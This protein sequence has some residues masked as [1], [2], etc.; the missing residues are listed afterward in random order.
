MKQWPGYMKLET[1]GLKVY[2]SSDDLRVLVGSWLKDAVRKYGIKIIGGEIYSSF[3]S[4]RDPD[5]PSPNKAKAEINPNGSIIIYD[6]KG[7]EGLYLSGLSGQGAVNWYFDGTRYAGA[8]VNS[9]LDRDLVIWTLQSNSGINLSTYNG[10]AVEIGRGGGNS[11]NLKASVVFA[12]ADLDVREMLSAGS[13]VS[14]GSK[15]CAEP[16]E[17]YGIRL[18]NAVEAPELKYYDSGVIYLQNGEATVHLDPIFLECIEPDTELAPWQIW[19]Q[20]YG[21]NDVYVAEV[22]TDY[23]VIKERD[24]GTSNNKVIWRFEAIRKNYA[25]IRLM[26]VTN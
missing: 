16:T 9:G 25:G 19:V 18:L 15:N 23:F 3:I 1:D 8:F 13:I 12:S 26:E 4:T 21:E 14:F 2:D 6:M 22:G 17:N 11:I 20:C 10:A 7:R 24:G 5:D